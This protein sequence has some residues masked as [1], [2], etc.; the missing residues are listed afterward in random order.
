[1][2][3]ELGVGE[4]KIRMD[5]IK[6][7]DGQKKILVTGPANKTAQAEEIMKRIDKPQGDELPRI[8]LPPFLKVYAVPAGN[9]DALVTMLKERYKENPSIRITASGTSSNLV[10]PY[11]GD[12]MEIGKLILGGG[13]KN[14]K[15]QL[16]NFSVLN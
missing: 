12:H 14:A 6:V 2:E 15:T 1:M 4:A 7:E 3:A 16:F 8:N 11:P 13:E 9:A 5:Y 10:W